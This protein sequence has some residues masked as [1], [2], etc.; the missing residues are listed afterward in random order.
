[1]TMRISINVGN[2]AKS[3]LSIQHLKVLIK[4]V[5]IQINQRDLNLQ[6]SGTRFIQNNLGAKKVIHSMIT[7]LIPTNR[8]A[9]D[10]KSF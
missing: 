9:I 8:Y 1:M 7:I 10:K 5:I 2:T 6:V 3:H 4:S